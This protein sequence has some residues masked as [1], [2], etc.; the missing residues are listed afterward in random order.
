MAILNSMNEHQEQM[1][2]ANIILNSITSMSIALIANFK[3]Q[4]KSNIFRQAEIKMRMICHK[5]EDELNNNRETITGDEV[6]KYIFDYDKV[7]EDFGNHSIPRHIKDKCI[8]LY[9]N[10]RHLP[11]MLNCVSDF[12]ISTEIDIVN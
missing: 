3:I 5:I 12:G 8:S 7:L 9:Q 6:S 10:K 1:R 4:E 11:S 2:Y